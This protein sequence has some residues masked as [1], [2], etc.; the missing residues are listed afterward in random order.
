[1]RTRSYK[2]I[3]RGSATESRR[4]IRI[5]AIDPSAP[6]MGVAFLVGPELVRAEVKN[7]RAHGISPAS[8]A[9]KAARLLDRWIARY[10]PEVIA[11]KNP[12]SIP[13][14]RTPRLRALARAITAFGRQEGI[15]VK[16]YGPLE[17]R[18]FVCQDTRPTKL[19]TAR[20]LAT[21]H[22]PWLAGYYEVE[23][24]RSWWRKR[25]WTHL[26]DAVA[27]GL[28]CLGERAPRQPRKEAA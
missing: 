5:L 19:E 26:F 12:F 18:R 25:Y 27:V 3:P 17:A 23:A 28:V 1:M 6:Y 10:Q 4:P 15:P 2:N 20:I 11:A 7:I 21:H 24:K 9:K 8:F 13:N 14:G 22:Y 16:V